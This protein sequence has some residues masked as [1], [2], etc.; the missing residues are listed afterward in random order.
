MPLWDISLIPATDITCQPIVKN[1]GI[2]DVIR[3]VIE[4][5]HIFV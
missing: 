4:N 1:H 2:D 3:G 5:H